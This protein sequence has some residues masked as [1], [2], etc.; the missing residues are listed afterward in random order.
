MEDSLSTINYDF[1]CMFCLHL[2]FFA[3]QNQQSHCA[4]QST[5]SNNLAAG[6]SN[7]PSKTFNILLGCQFLPGQNIFLCIR[8]FSTRAIKP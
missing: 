5:I 3:E 6:R 8:E 2:L 4:A 1:A 7:A